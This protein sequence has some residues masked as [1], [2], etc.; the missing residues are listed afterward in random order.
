MQNGNKNLTKS[1]S[2]QLSLNNN[3]STKPKEMPAGI[4]NEVIDPKI[5]DKKMNS[6]YNTESNSDS[7]SDFDD[8]EVE[9]EAEEETEEEAEEAEEEEEEEEDY[10]D[11]DDD[12][13]VAK[14]NKTSK[15]KY[16]LQNTYKPHELISLMEVGLK[17]L[18]IQLKA[19]KEIS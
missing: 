2:D 19:L 7:K 5:K 10:D 8:K 15:K 9:E 13:T 12:D 18:S 17:T 14:T 6:L 1:F 3:R 4:E 11:D 16:D